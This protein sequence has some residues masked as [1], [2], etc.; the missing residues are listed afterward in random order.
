M[1]ILAALFLPFFLFSCKVLQPVKDTSVTYLLDPAVPDR[2]LSSPSPAVAIN[3][4]S[5]PSYLDRQQIVTRVKAGELKMSNYHLWA[6]P[7][8]TGISRVVSMN[9]ARLTGSTNIQPIDNFVTLEYTSLV[10]LRISQFEPADHDHVVLACTWKVQPVRGQPLQPR[11]FRTEVPFTPSADKLDLSPRIAA[12]NEALAR[13][14][15]VI[16]RSL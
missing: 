10:E 1:K 13:L 15:R 3:R 2:T 14:S 11:T 5:L 6:E 16:A 4:P 12:M 8:D 7:L 9:L